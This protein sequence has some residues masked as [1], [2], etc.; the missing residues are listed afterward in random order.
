MLKILFSLFFWVSLLFSSFWGMGEYVYAAEAWSPPPG[1][2]IHSGPSGAG[3]SSVSPS[4]GPSMGTGAAMGAMG[5]S[6]MA[7]LLAGNEAVA[8]AMNVGAAGLLTKMGT[9]ATA[10]ESHAEAAMY[11]MSAASH[12][13]Q[14]I[15]LFTSSKKNHD[16]R[17][18][19][20]P[21]YRPYP[22]EREYQEA[23]AMMENLKGQG[24]TVT[25]NGAVKDPEG[26]TYAPKAIATQL[27]KKNPAIVSKLQ[28]LQTK[29]MK[30]MQAKA[31]K[32]AAAYNESGQSP[33]VSS[34]M[35]KNGDEGGIEGSDLGGVGGRFSRGG[36]SLGA[37]NSEE[38]GAYEYGGLAYEGG[39]FPS[40]AR[41]V[42]G[43]NKVVNGTSIG[44]QSDDIF[45][46]T[47]RR[48]LEQDGQN[49][50]MK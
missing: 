29:K 6:M 16:V 25:A 10:R 48:Y 28:K 12:A 26:K 43:L 35:G 27:K 20:S 5:L 34:Q 7:G 1:E 33:G 50:F 15:Q 2:I 9:A 37:N 8:G 36:G 11:Y 38:E 3:P 45:D 42:S 30:E 21:T 31:Q 46:L 17:N 32:Y 4:T 44:I 14:A 13:A 39:R 47:H 41:N 22:Y 40:S 49:Q 18:A 24:Y 23:Q 19:A